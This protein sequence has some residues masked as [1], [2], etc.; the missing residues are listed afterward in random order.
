MVEMVLS[1]PNVSKTAEPG[2][3]V[4]IRVYER[5]KEYLLRLLI[6]IEIKGR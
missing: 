4:I 2:Q 3:F 1:A 5:V 6:L